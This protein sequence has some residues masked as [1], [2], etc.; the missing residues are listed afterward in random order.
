MK[1]NLEENGHKVHFM[2]IF[3]SPNSMNFSDA[4]YR[5]VKKCQK[6][7]NLFRKHSENHSVDALQV[8]YEK[9]SVTFWHRWGQ[10]ENKYTVVHNVEM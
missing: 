3:V 6:C 7:D 10:T 4:L 8:A 2:F 1:K 9:I 5:R